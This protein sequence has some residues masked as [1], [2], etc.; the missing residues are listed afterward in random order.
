MPILII[1]LI[2]ILIHMNTEV[3]AVAEVRKRDVGRCF[4]K[5]QKCMY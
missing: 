4:T 1:I 5:I 2:L 3:C